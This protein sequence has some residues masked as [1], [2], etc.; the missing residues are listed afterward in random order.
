MI[1]IFTDKNNKSVK[2]YNSVGKG[3]YISVVK[4]A[5]QHHLLDFDAYI[6]TI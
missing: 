3:L 5:T 4:Y 2:R 6:P 1:C